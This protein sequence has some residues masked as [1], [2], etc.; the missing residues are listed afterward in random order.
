M[1]ALEWGQREG[2]KKHRGIDAIERTDGFGSLDRCTRDPVHTLFQGYR[3]WNIIGR[4][5][6]H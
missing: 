2:R 6:P 1:L 5:L 3:V 4:L